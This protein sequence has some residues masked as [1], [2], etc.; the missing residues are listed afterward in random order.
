MPRRFVHAA[1]LHLDSPFAGVGTLRD[2]LAERMRD[3]SL[4]AWDALVDCCLEEEAEFLVLA[5]DLFDRAD[6]TPRG[7][8]RVRRGVERLHDAGVRVF[9]VHG[10]HDPLSGRSPLAGLDGVHVFRRDVPTSETLDAPAGPVTVHGVSFGRREVMENLARAFA[11]GDAPG[12]HVGVLHCSLGEREG[13][14]TYAPCTVADLVA[15]RMDYWALGHIHAYSEEH[16]DPPIIY[17]GTLQGRSPKPGERGPHGAVVVEFD[18]D[19]VLGHRR[20]ELDRVRFEALELPIDGLADEAAL[21]RALRQAALDVVAHADGRLVLLRVTL[22]GRGP[23]HEVLV[24]DDYLAQLRVALDDQEAEDLVWERIVSQAGPAV[25][26]DELRAS[27]A[28]AAEVVAA[29]DALAA[30]PAGLQEMLDGLA[31]SFTDTALAGIVEE[32]AAARLA[33]ARE[34]ALGLILEQ[35]GAA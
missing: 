2:G 32:R 22:T 26:L 15:A 20:V 21:E 14:G 9:V 31:R 5:G 28:F 29:F 25:D 18:G 19:R 34:L 3:A 6:G 4:D 7:R 16:A 11:R 30:D 27:N 33:A 12:L 17:A 35:D 13:H 23:L 24:R 10:N 8:A 1:D